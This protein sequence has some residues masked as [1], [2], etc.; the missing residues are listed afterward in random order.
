MKA[1]VEM[2]QRRERESGCE[3]LKHQAWSGAAYL[4]GVVSAVLSGSSG[5]RSMGEGG[6]ETQF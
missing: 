5:S 2:E 6:T 4:D 1:Y 3:V